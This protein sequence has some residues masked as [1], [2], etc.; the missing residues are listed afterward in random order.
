MKKLGY[1]I[2]ASVAIAAIL[3][4]IANAQQGTSYLQRSDDATGGVAG[5]VKAD[6]RP[7]TSQSLGPAHRIQVYTGNQ[8][9]TQLT[10]QPL[11]N[12]RVDKDNIQV[13]EDESNGKLDAT[14][15]VDEQNKVTIA[16][17]QPV[18]AEKVLEIRMFGLTPPNQV[19][20]KSLAYSVNGSYEGM[21]QTMPFGVVQVRTYGPR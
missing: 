12:V 17:A 7:S 19:F 20:P 3:A 11:Y 9:L 1:F 15:T 10:I 21:S 13:I 6:I 18:P 14:V 2:T 5:I 4:P 16:F 8:P